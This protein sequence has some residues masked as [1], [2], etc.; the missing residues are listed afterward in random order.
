MRF[1]LEKL[2]LLLVVVAA[3]KCRWTVVE[4]QECGGRL[5]LRAALATL[6][7]N[8]RSEERRSE[9]N[10]E[11]ERAQIGK[12]EKCVFWETQNFVWES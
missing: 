2:L 10:I 9:W 7:H 3:A 4:A 6:V 1:A 12:L 8:R 5:R 11:V